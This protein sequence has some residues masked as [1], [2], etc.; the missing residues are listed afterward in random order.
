MLLNQE[1]G[2]NNEILDGV[3]HVRPGNNYVIHDTF[4]IT[5][6]Y[7]VNGAEEHEI[8]TYMKVTTPSSPTQTDHH[9]IKAP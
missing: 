8:Y 4:T 7:D 6:K 1:P 5:S 3:Q 2:R 9:R